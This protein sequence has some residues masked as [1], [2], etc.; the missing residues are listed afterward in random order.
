[1]IDKID[2]ASRETRKERKD[3]GRSLEPGDVLLRLYSVKKR[4]KS[5][6]SCLQ[7]HWVS[8]AFAETYS[9]NVLDVSH[10]ATP[11]APEAWGTTPTYVATEDT[12]LDVDH[13]G[14]GDD[15]HSD[16]LGV[17]RVFESIPAL[18]LVAAS[19]MWNDAVMQKTAAAINRTHS[20]RAQT[21]LTERAS[22]IAEN[23]HGQNESHVTTSGP[24]VLL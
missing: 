9:G 2:A 23:T 5:L 20:E 15:P 24:N 16:P 1:M 7:R 22:C 17:A 11:T 4:P 21:G 18:L 6:Q 19:L 8:T 14:H 13:E 3:K 12:D 10:N